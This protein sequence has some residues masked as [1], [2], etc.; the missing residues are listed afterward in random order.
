MVALLRSQHSTKCLTL[1]LA[2]LAIYLLWMDVGFYLELQRLAPRSLDPPSNSTQPYI[3]SPFQPITVKLLMFPPTVQFIDEPLAYLT[4]HYTR[5]ATWFSPDA[6][7]LLGVAVAAISA[8]FMMQEELRCRQLGVLLFSVRDY[9]DALDG[10]IYRERKNLHQFGQVAAPD[11]FGWMMDG[12]CDG[13]ADVFRFVAFAVVLQRLFSSGRLAG[14]S[15]LPDLG[16]GSCHQRTP[17][18]PRPTPLTR[19]YTAYVRYRRPAVIMLCVGLQSLLSSIIWNFF[20]ISYHTTLET[21]IPYTGGNLVRAASVQADIL[22][23]SPM[24]TVSYFWRLVNPQNITQVQLL[25]ILYGREA[26]L[27]VSV[28]LLGFL[29]PVIVGLG[30]YMH[31]QY[32]QHAVHVAAFSS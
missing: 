25:A 14:Y 29:P 18:P 17:P 3:Y 20:M 15:L 12:I 5:L 10:T 9:I 32:A 31:L 16:A 4:V 2:G 28:Q 26:E 13:L 23:S 11:H 21:D 8:R 22:R 6:M 7:S 27:M 30:S 19:L 24:W 1:F